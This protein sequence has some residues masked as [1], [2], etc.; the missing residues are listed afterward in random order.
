[1]QLLGVFG[2]H[3]KH[4]QIAVDGIGAVSGYSKYTFRVYCSL[5]ATDNPSGTGFVRMGFTSQS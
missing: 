1:M 4:L 3:H 2:A 5:H